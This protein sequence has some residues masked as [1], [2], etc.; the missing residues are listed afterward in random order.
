MRTTDLY[1]R[2]LGAFVPDAV[3]AA[4]AV[5][6]GLCPPEAPGRLDM[7][8]AA[9]AGA[10]SAPEMALRAS[11]EALARASMDPAEL[12][13]VLYADTWHQGPE[14]WFPQSHLQHHLGTGDALA[15][16]IRQGCNALFAGLELAAAHL[17]VRPAPGGAL[18]VSSDNFGTPHMNRWTS[19]SSFMG[20]GACALVLAPGHGAVEVLS[21]N[22]MVV[23][24]L[25]ETH[26]FGAPAFPPE[27]TTDHGVVDFAAREA[28][29]TRHLEETGAGTDLWMDVHKKM[30]KVV[31]RTMAEAGVTRADLARA[32][33]TS[34]GPEDLEHRWLAVLDLPL[35]AST[36][37]YGR[38]VGHI[39]A[40]DPFLGLRHL[41][42]NKEV[43]PGDHVILGGLGSGVTVS[44]AVVRVLD[45]DDQG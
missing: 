27:A 23:P 44:C 37:D 43:G 26:R 29:F 11:R 28:A 35:S 40:G 4:S 5:A 14:G 45:P 12:S 41:M 20:D 8:G 19:N 30:L 13:L 21:V 10:L 16:E 34:L 1:L 32:A 31:S 33:F 15:L 24:E 38:R 9:V 7:T 3:P 36:W 39:G 2:G 6:E 18:V 22:S 25:E 17:A 42:D